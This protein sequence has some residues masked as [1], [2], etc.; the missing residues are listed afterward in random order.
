MAA[1]A[2][3]AAAEAAAAGADPEPWHPWTV[4][5][6]WDGAAGAP[7]CH[8]GYAPLLPLL[9]GVLPP[10]SP[11]VGGGL[12]AMAHPARLAGVAGLRSLSAASPAAGTA[13][14]Y[15][16]GPVWVPFSY[17]AT[18]TAARAYG[19]VPGAA[20]VAADT[21]RRLVANA[22]AEWTRTGY[23]WEVYDGVGGG[24]QRGRQFCGW[25][26]LVV[27]AAAERYEGVL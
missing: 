10:S 25:S 20:A 26:A 15:W 16:T 8:D 13:D 24:G 5:C 3:A 19:G 23:V 12:A 1:V 7:V 9:L 18:V 14:G 6:D 2:A 4:L 17:L 22:V 11:A 27:L 21:R